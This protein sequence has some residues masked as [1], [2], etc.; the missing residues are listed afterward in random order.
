MAEKEVSETGSAPS[1]SRYQ[2]GI[3]DYLPTANSFLPTVGLEPEEKQRPG[4]GLGWNRGS[5][6][7]L[8]HPQ[9]NPLRP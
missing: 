3:S 5:L 9:P 8:S 4:G 1:L 2:F 7:A 6:K